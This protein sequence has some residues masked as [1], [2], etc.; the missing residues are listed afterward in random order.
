MKCRVPVQQPHLQEHDR[1]R[2]LHT[3]TRQ[4][5]G[6]TRD[7]FGRGK[8]SADGTRLG[9]AIATTGE[10]INEAETIPH[11]TLPREARR[12][13][14]TPEWLRPPGMTPQ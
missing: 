6:D 5:A 3:S 4:L 14:A 2:P 1:V 12:L 10:Q 9:K 13:G 8:T 7:N 11:M